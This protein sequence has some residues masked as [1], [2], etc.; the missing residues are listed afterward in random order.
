[1]M[2]MAI[3]SSSYTTGLG[4]PSINPLAQYPTLTMILISKSTE[5]LAL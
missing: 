2:I 1:M 3:Y 5:I 4:K